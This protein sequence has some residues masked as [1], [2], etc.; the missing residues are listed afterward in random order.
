MFAFLDDMYAVASKERISQVTAHV[1]KSIE[2]GAGVQPK[3]GK[4][5]MWSRRRGTAGNRRSPQ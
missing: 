4:F 1:A 2:E 5:G 3:L